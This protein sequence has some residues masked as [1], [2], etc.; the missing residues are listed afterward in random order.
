MVPILRGR[1]DTDDRSLVTN[2]TPSKSGNG[3]CRA[4]RVIATLAM[5][6]IGIEVDGS[7]PT[8]RGRT[9]KMEGIKRNGNQR[10]SSAPGVNATAI[11][12]F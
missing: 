5:S 3:S 7:K 6:L 1:F 10:N 12:G 4:K 11:I 8:L 2:G 9:R